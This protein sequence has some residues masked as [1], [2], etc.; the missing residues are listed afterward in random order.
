[1]YYTIEEN[2]TYCSGEEV[3]R[4]NQIVI[5]DCTEEE[6]KEIRKLISR[7][8]DEYKKRRELEPE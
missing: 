2:S 5:T 7:L 8:Y 1:M 6:L 3:Y 4:K